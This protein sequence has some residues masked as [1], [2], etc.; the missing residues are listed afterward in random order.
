M[1]REDAEEKLVE[2]L[3]KVINNQ[4]LVLMPAQLVGTSQELLIT[5]DMLIKQKKIKKCKL[6][7]EKLVT[8]INSIHEFNLEFLNRELQQS[9]ISNDYNPFRSK[10]IASITDINTQKL[11]S[12]IIIYPS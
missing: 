5:L 7:I 2:L 9:I 4:K 11:D 6:Y 10:N 3:N 8:E 12:G 1:S